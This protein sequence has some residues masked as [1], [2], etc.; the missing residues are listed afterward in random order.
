MTTEELNNFTREDWRELGFYYDFD[1]SAARWQLI[2]SR[3][4]LL[5]FRDILFDYAADPRH[6]GLSEHDH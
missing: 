6:A 3:D 1:K 4:G 5:K 2:G